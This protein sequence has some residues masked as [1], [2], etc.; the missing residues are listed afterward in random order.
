M[1]EFKRIVWIK[2]CPYRAERLDR[3][4]TV[5]DFCSLPQGVAYFAER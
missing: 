3:Q 2:E 4:Q 1:E 5:L